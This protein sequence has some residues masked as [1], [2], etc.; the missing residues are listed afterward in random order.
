MYDFQPEEVER[1]QKHVV[2]N[3]LCK[4]DVLH[5]IFKVLNSDIDNASW[6]VAK[7]NVV[8]F[9]EWCKSSEI[10]FHFV[11]DVHE[12]DSIPAKR[13]Y[14]MQKLLKKYR[15]YVKVYLHSSVVITRNKLVQSALE[16]ALD[17]MHPNRPLKILLAN[18]TERERGECNIPQSTWESCTAF[19]N[20]N[21]LPA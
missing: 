13:L 21:K 8:H 12:C 7:R 1:F 10:R 14:S 9:M 5:L 6:K 11:F 16:V 3:L 20:A 15:P 4:D 17:L 19:F 18:P 2:L